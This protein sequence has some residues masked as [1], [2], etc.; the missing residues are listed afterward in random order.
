[1]IMAL[2]ILGKWVGIVLDDDSGK[3][4]GE[5]QGKKYFSCPDNFGIF[6][7]PNQVGEMGTNPSKWYLLFLDRPIRSFMNYHDC[8]KVLILYNVLIAVLYC[9]YCN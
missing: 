1:M 2:L 8:D 5:V 7:R 3:N 4:N 9:M 6:V